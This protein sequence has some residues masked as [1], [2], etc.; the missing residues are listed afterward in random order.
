MSTTIWASC[1]VSFLI[2]KFWNQLS[3]LAIIIIFCDFT[4]VSMI[5]FIYWHCSY[6]NQMEYMNHQ[7]CL[8]S[9]LLIHQGK[10]LNILFFTFYPCTCSFKQC[11]HNTCRYASRVPFGYACFPHEFIGT[12]DWLMK[13][14]HPRIL[15]FSYFTTGGH[16]PAFQVPALLAQDI[17]D[18]ARKVEALWGSLPSLKVAWKDQFGTQGCWLQRSMTSFNFSFLDDICCTNH[19]NYSHNTTL[20]LPSKQKGMNFF[21]VCVGK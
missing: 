16:F 1:E 20:E 21:C 4:T 12:T 19:Q 6:L 5:T 11:L 18:F 13:V 8:I 10:I 17:R 7:S 2:I 9:T 14:F 3:I 15:H